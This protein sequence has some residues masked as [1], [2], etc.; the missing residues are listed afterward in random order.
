MA[1]PEAAGE[2]VLRAPGGW[3]WRNWPEDAADDEILPQFWGEM[4]SLIKPQRK[5]DLGRSRR[6]DITAT[7]QSLS[8]DW[9]WT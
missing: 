2:L 8:T 1:H 4:G 9:G 7:V 5:E 3:L 6:G